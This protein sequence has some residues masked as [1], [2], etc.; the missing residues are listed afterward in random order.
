MMVVYDDDVI[1]EYEDEHEDEMVVCWHEMVMVEV[2]IEIWI[3]S[4]SHSN[5]KL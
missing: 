1:H 4:Y 2:L 3:V 5:V